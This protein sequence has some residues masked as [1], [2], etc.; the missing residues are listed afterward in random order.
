MVRVVVET[1]APP[2][3]GQFI[4]SKYGTDCCFDSVGVATVW[5]SQLTS[6]PLTCVAGEGATQCKGQT[7]MH[8]AAKWTT[9]V[10]YNVQGG[11]FII[12]RK[13]ICIFTKM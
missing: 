2:N 6:N 5:H 7:A 4:E 11:A 3:Q 10:V 13:Q 12:N 8:V 9:S 1:T